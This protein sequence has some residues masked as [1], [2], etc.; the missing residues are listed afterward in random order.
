MN[1]PLACKLLML[2]VTVLCLDQPLAGQGK[3]AAKRAPAQGIK[4]IHLTV[5]PARQPKP[6]LKYQLLPELLERKP[7][8]AATLYLM[9][10]QIAS[11]EHLGPLRK[12]VNVW[13]KQPVAKLPRDKITK[14]LDAYRSALHHVELAARRQDCDWGLPI[15]EGFGMLLPPLNHFRNLAK[16]LCVKIRLA[17]AAGRIDEA[18]HDLQTG[19]GMARH[20]DEGPTLIQDLVATAITSLLNDR[21]QE[22]MQAKEAPNL[23]WALA[24][25][26][27]PMIDLGKSMEY[28]EASLYIAF[29]TLRRKD[30]EKIT[31]AEWMKLQNELMGL[32]SRPPH[33][34][35]FERHGELVPA[36]IALKLYPEAKKYLIRHG[37]EPEKVEAL[38]VTQAI[39]TYM[40]ETYEVWR[41]YLFK[42]FSLPYW[43]AREG[44]RRF[45]REFARWRAGEGGANIFASILPSLSRAYFVTA[46]VQRQI[47]AL[48][49][50]EAV[51]VYAADHDGKLPARLG[52]VKDAP[53][54]IDPVLGR[55]FGYQA[56]AGR[57]ILDAPAPPGMPARKGWRYIVTVRK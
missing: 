55:P 19:Y 41:D 39:F 52:D 42:W 23:Y 16:V 25:L 49:T 48:Q 28:E 1:K 11:G 8:D 5:R 29:P 24:R 13:L 33:P 45:E 56:A 14:M 10:L 36:A 6:A 44:Q 26:P 34:Y 51:R 18:I 12:D 38:S 4:E 47:A 31:P 9:A 15:S 57:F 50:I 46:Q 32:L 22:L 7:G 21:V 40:H 3:G 53:P 20:L 17:I 35:P 54:P 27:R 43:Q 30:P 2:C 37:Y